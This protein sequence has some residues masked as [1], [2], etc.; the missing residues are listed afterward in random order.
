MESTISLTKCSLTIPTTQGVFIT[1]LLA[2]ER[3]AS[4]LHSDH[5]A[6]RSAVISLVRSRVKILRTWY[7]KWLELCFSPRWGAAFVLRY[8]VGFVRP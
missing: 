7:R 3:T 2:V 8:Y 1:G 6:T 4:S 5:V